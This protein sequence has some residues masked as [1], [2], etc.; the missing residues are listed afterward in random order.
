MF[1]DEKESVIVSLVFTRDVSREES[2]SLDWGW[3]VCGVAEIG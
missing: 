3:E 2:V 1:V